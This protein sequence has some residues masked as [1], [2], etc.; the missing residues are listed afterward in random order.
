MSQPKPQD[1]AGLR[2]DPALKMDS[3]PGFNIGYLSY[4]T[5]KTQTSKLEVRQALDMAIN[6]KAIVDAVYQGQA[7]GSHGRMTGW[8]R[9]EIIRGGPVCC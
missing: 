9:H 1:I 2:A 6:R 5:E 7:Q 4:N 3:A 8:A